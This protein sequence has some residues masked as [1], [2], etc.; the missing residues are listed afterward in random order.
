MKLTIS[1]GHNGLRR[2]S[3]DHYTCF[4]F[5]LQVINFTKKQRKI[6][7]TAT[8]KSPLHFRFSFNISDNFNISLSFSRFLTISLFCSLF[9]HFVYKRPF[10]RYLRLNFLFC[11][12]VRFWSKQS[13]Y[14]CFLIIFLTKIN[15]KP[16]NWFQ[17]KQPCWISRVFIFSFKSSDLVKTAHTQIW[18]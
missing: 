2:F 12:P 3:C 13:H 17:T 16:A 8:K 9:V 6:H 15:A 18:T 1:G 10:A 14:I 5:G 4:N 11:T 7:S